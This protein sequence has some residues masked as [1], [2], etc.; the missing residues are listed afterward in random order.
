MT[1]E[2]ARLL[3]A[4]GAVSR[5]QVQ[6][7]LAASFHQRVPFVSALLDQ[8]ALDDRSFAREVACSSIPEIR[9]VVPVAELVVRLPPHMCAS[10]LAVPVRQDTVTGT[11]DV[12]TADPLDS[13]VQSE[14][15]FHLDAPIRLVRAPVAAL[16]DVV[17]VI[18][19][20]EEPM[21]QSAGPLASRTA[22]FRLTPAFGSAAVERSQLEPIPLVRRSTAPRAAEAHGSAPTTPAAR[23]AG[24]TS[25]SPQRITPSSAQEQEAVQRIRQARGRDEVITELVAALS[26]AAARCGVLVHRRHAWVGWT[27]TPELGDR[28]AFLRVSVSTGEDSALSAVADK[29]WFLGHLPATAAHEPLLRFLGTP[30]S[31]VCLVAVEVAGRPVMLLLCTDVTDTM[32][33]TR[34]AELLAD[35]AGEAL[36]RILSSEKRSR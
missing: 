11:I 35:E 5:A 2:L 7:A 33:T 13:H 29:G 1:V 21:E 4:S 20:D 6:A 12:A 34:L 18:D 22:A 30:A 3:L 23:V 10:L 24:S 17:L 9:H 26:P 14:F 15:A 16:R 19:P 28:E 8:G 32:N 36:A 27:C 31:E 25:T